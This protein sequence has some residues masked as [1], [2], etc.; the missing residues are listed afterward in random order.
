MPLSIIK[1]CVGPGDGNKFVL[2][3]CI[4]SEDEC[5]SGSDNYE[6]TKPFSEDEVK[7]ALFQM[8]KNKVACLMGFQLSSIKF[9]GMW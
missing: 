3:P 8:E 6:L 7:D 9:V 5:V 4:W 2:E 1:L